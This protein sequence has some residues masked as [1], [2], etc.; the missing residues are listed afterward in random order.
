[1]KERV[2]FLESRN[3]EAHN[4]VASKNICFGKKINTFGNGTSGSGIVKAIHFSVIKI[5]DYQAVKV[6]ET[7][8]GKSVGL[9]VKEKSH[10]PQYP[11]SSVSSLRS[12]I[13]S[14]RPHSSQK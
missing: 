11:G 7:L 2:N 1:L 6:G 12:V 14:G 4:I 10:R 5:C 3:V 9:N 13:A 8:P